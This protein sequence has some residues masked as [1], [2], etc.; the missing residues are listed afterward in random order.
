MSFRHLGSFRQKKASKTIPRPNTKN[1]LQLKSLATLFQKLFPTRKLKT[2]KV[3]AHKVFYSNQVK[4]EKYNFEAEIE[5][6]QRDF[7]LPLEK[8]E[9]ATSEMCSERA[10]SEGK[11]SSAST[12]DFWMASSSR[13]ILLS[14]FSN[15]VF[16]SASNLAI[17]SMMLLIKIFSSLVISSSA[18]SVQ[19]GLI[20][21]KINRN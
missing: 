3:P 21:E 7:V 11:F 9:A 18:F 2:E 4:A 19:E 17:L 1:I 13:A 20:E 10:Q 16:M 6:F 12:S 15:S 8:W 5:R 14:R